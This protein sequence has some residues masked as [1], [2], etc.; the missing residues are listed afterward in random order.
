[1][2]HCGRGEGPWIMADLEKGL[3]GANITH[4]NEAPLRANYI[5]AMLK[6]GPNVFA[7][8]GGDAQAGQLT[9]Y[10]EGTRPS[11]ISI[12]DA[13]SFLRCRLLVFA[14]PIA[15]SPGRHSFGCIHLGVCVAQQVDSPVFVCCHD[16]VQEHRCRVAGIITRCAKRA[17]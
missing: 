11:G 17:A 5:F 10:F 8:K 12:V 6:G 2:N 1:M 16:V 7:L 3:W 9:T 15:P 4:S 14:L 13:C